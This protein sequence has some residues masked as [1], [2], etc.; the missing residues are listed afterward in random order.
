MQMKHFFCGGIALALAAFFMCGATAYAATTLPNDNHD[1]TNTDTVDYCLT[2]HDVEIDLF[3]F[4]KYATQAE[5]E[6]AI[7][8]SA[9][10]VFFIR[11]KDIPSSEWERVTTGFTVDYS[12]LKQSPLEEGYPVTVTLPEITA[13]V[14][15]AITFRVYVKAEEKALEEIVITRPPRK[16]AYIEGEAFDSTEMEVH[17]LYSDGDSEEVLNYD[18]FPSGALAMTD[19]AVT[20]SYDGMEVKQPIQVAAKELAKIEI[21]TPADKTCYTAG[22][23]FD[24]AGMVVTAFYNNGNSRTI[25]DYTYAPAEAFTKDDNAVQIS[26]QEGNVTQTAK[27]AVTVTSKGSGKSRSDEDEDTDEEDP[28]SGGASSGDAGQPPASS[29]PS[30][31]VPPDNIQPGPA[32]AGA[33]AFLQPDAG[34]EPSVQQPDTKP[35]ETPSSKPETRQAAPLEPAGKTL[36]QIDTRANSGIPLDETGDLFAVEMFLL[37]LCGLTAVGFGTSIASDLRVLAWYEQKKQDYLR[38]YGA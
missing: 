20:V 9:Q 33:A 22:E 36:L 29:V 34:S 14:R 17:A 7:T 1:R 11:N 24:P 27:L 4:Q 26:F 31:P 6:D 35:P 15:S 3:E 10:M 16:T 5:L 28:G 13:G 30:G 2:A 18:I 8:E 38:R 25:T 21:T 19:S 12:N 23:S 32:S 37:T